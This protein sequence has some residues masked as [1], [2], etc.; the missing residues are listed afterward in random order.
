MN[1][2]LH[3]HLSFLGSAVEHIDDPWRSSVIFDFYPTFLS[4]LSMVL[5]VFLK[6][7]HLGNRNGLDLDCGV[8]VLHFHVLFCFFLAGVVH[9][10]Y[11]PSIALYCEVVVLSWYTYQFDISFV[12]C[13][14]FC[15]GGR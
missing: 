11:L 6:V 3:L 12:F 15:Y 14:A 9:R 2:I 10:H 13:P 4:I 5:V 1:C 8:S 7:V